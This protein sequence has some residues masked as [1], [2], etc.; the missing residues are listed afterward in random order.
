MVS[1]DGILNS[2][3][4]FWYALQIGQL[5]SIGNWNYLV[6]L[7]FVILQGPSVAILI[8]AGIS[9]GLFNPL[10]AGLTSVIGS[11]IADVFWYNIG[12]LG[13][14]DRYYRKKKGK[15]K[16]LVELFQNG[17]QKHYLKIL[18]LGK[19]SLGL[20]IPA[21]ISAG[22]CRI[23]WRRWFPVV[24]IGEILFT[25]SMVSLGYFATESIMHVDTI[26]KVV[27]ISTT[28][29]CLIILLVVIPIEIKKMLTIA[30]VESE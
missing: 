24:I 12:Q 3:G 2:F 28:A 13:K 22:L 1:I 10:M 21:V 25:L 8:G 18:L 7:V 6:L 15:R 14:L 11:L 17:M 30:A 27:G 23:E 29:I 19:L 5:P 20:A 26:V 9:A 16:E 4:Q